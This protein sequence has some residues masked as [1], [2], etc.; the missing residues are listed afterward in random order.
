MLQ[1]LNVTVY[2]SNNGSLIEGTYADLIC[3]ATDLD[4]TIDTVANWYYNGQ[5]IDA[6]GAEYTTSKNGSKHMLHINELRL[7][8][9]NNGQYTCSVS[10]NNRFITG[11][12]SSND[13]I[14]LSVT[15]KYFI[16]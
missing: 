9:D 3:T 8:R 10:V 5:L 14:T 15:S 13:T 11:I 12:E 4:S 7:S 1:T 2:V 16:F 6:S